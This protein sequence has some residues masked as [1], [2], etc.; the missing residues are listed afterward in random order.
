MRR[1]RFTSCRNVAFV[2]GTQYLFAVRD[3]Q[4]NF[5]TNGDVNG[6]STF[7]MWSPEGGA[8]VGRRSDLAGLRQYLAQRRGAE[9]RRERQSEFPESDLSDH[10][11]L[12]DQAADRD[13]LR[14]RHARQASRLQP[15]NWSAI[16]PT[17]ATSCS[18]NTARSAI[19][20]SPMLDRTI[21][22]GI[23]AGAGAAMFR[24]HLRHGQ[25]AGQ[26]LAQPRLYLQR[27]PLRQRSDLRQQPAAGRAA[28]LSAGR[29]ALQAPERLLCRPQ[30]GMGAA[31]L[32]CR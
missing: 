17:S 13:D 31:I 32:F 2:A 16:A 21:H 4:V 27:F 11:V 9:L 10:S 5:S 7:S 14:N 29:G 19:A 28:S 18:A 23:E 12:P 1:T 22:Q 30:S 3:Q 24:E 26:D 20:T 25:C 15:G 6:R 8:A